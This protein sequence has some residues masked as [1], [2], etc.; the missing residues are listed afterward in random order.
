M[1][2]AQRALGRK[3]IYRELDVVFGLFCLLAGVNPHAV[4]Q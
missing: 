4:H 2:R 3:V 1:A